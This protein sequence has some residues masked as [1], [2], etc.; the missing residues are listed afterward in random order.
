VESTGPSS[1]R[2][3][4]HAPGDCACAGLCATLL[5]M[6]EP[7]LT[8]LGVYRPQISKET[9]RKQ[10]QV[11]EDDEMTREHFAGLVLI[12]AIVEGLAGPFEMI[13][14]GQMQAEYMQVG[15]D[16]GLLSDDGETLIQR[17]MKCVRGSGPLRFAVYLHFYDPQ[18]PLQ[19]QGG[20]VMGPPV[21]EIPV[22][23]SLLMPYVPTD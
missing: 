12:E 18:R 17:Q 7:R 20:E 11:T 19:W 21:Q 13:K 9:W 14:F 8:V 4:V 10:W 5:G 16:E 15:Y 1:T 2:L 22:R 3:P 6:P 23:L